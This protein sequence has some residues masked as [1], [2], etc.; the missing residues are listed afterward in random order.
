MQKNYIKMK[1]TPNVLASIVGGN[2]EGD[3]EIEITSFAKIEEAKKGDLSFISNKKYTPYAETTLASAL[4]VSRDFDSPVK[5]GV[6]LIKVDDPYPAL[7]I[8]LSH[9]A[10]NDTQ[11]KKGVEEPSHIGNNVDL[12]E[13]S[14]IGAF[15]YIDNSVK[16]GKD[17]KIFPHSYI[18]EGVEIGEGTII[19]PNVSVYAGVKIGKRCIIHSGAVIGSDGFGFAPLDGK[20]IK[21]PQTGIVRIEDDVE[22][23]ANTTVDRAT[24]GETVIGHGTKLDNLIQVAHN[25]RIGHDNVFAA[26]TG[27]AGSAII[28]DSN[29]IGGQVGF[30][31]H[32]KFGSNC[33][34]GAQSGIHKGYGDGQRVIGYPAMDLG[35]FA[36]VQVLTKRLPAL[37]R[38]VEE[39]KKE[40]KK[41]KIQ[42]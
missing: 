18:G 24:F 7:A 4:L 29:R 8:L 22:I 12:G 19:Y 25:V 10:K 21:I 27:I 23:G 39:L 20:Y 15:A 37:F 6:T 9:F 30:A 16:I 38:D 40:I 41:D 11:S 35:T 1:I 32:I 14:Y 36:K 3:G 34:V 42:K 17:V 28:G 31:G 5:E 13:G 2:V 26:Q 33:E